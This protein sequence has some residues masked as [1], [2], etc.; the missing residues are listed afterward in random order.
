MSNKEIVE[1]N[2]VFRKFI[3]G[4][5]INFGAI[6]EWLDMNFVYQLNADYEWFAFWRV[7]ND[8]RLF[9]S[10]MAKVSKFVVQMNNWFPDAPHACKASE[11]NRYRR[12]YLGDTIHGKWNRKEF[13]DSTVVKKHCKQSLA[14]FDRLNDLCCKL[15]AGL[16]DVLLAA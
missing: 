10:G 1:L 7:A 13:F 3:D 9:E 4:L 5:P 14:G 11:V 2:Y 15:E 8:M 12:G 6:Y 16:R